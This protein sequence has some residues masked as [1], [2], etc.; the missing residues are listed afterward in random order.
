[1][2]LNKIFRIS[3]IILIVF[4]PLL[5][6]TEVKLPRLIG[7]GMVLQRDVPLKIWGSASPRE[8]VNVKL[9]NQNYRAVANAK[10]SW[11]IA[12]PAMPAGGPYE[13]QIN[14]LILK[15]ILIGDVWLCSGQSNMELPIRRV[16]DLYQHEIEKVNNTNIR[17]FRVPLRYNFTMP[18][19]DVQGGA[20]VSANQQNIYDFSAVAYFFANEL[21]QKYHVPIG[22]INN[23]IGGSPAEAWLSGEAL[24]KYP[25]LLKESQKCAQSGYIDSVLNAEN[26]Y[27]KSWFSELNKKD[28][29]VSV[30][31]KENADFS[32]LP[33]MSVPG[34]WSD[35]LSSQKNGSVWFHRE[36]N[37]P[38]SLAARNAVLRLG[39]IIDSDSAFVNGTFVGT[40][41]YQYPPRIYNIPK[42]LLKKGRNSITVR[43]ISQSGKGGF[44]EEKPYEIRIGSQV[45]DLT[46]DWQFHSGAEMQ[47]MASQTFFQYKPM[48]LFNGMINPLLNFAIKGVIWY[49]GESNTGRTKEYA[50]LFPDLI[51]NWRAKFN[52]PELPFL[53]VQLANLGSAPKQPQESGWA[54]LREVQRK[55]LEKPRTGMAVAIDLGEWNDIHPLNKKEVGRRLSLEAQRVAYNETAIV[56]SGPKLESAEIDGTAVVLTFSSVGSGLYANSVLEGFAIAGEN[57]RFEWANAVVI[58]KNKVKV[59]SEGVGLPQT[60]RYAWAD[61]PGNVNLKNKEGLPASPFMIT[62]NNFK[63]K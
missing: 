6:R 45:V 14:N 58:A 29:G 13:M 2:C 25:E 60:V 53:Y 56:S 39:R 17:L 26:A 62:Y 41:S 4:L 5:G 19:N 16:L 54:E 50:Q 20:W 34:Y 38:D 59:W 27:R 47:P 40:V 55:T 36:F 51:D 30:W 7:N 21:Y 28:K 43:V 1:M 49:Q 23:A 15:D 33:Q 63:G 32:S 10:G 61:N 46:G 35:K 8:K 48:G 42:G 11:E 22:L 9:S 57:G 37:I 44:V 24:K 31:S 18:E 12:L 3:V 52:N